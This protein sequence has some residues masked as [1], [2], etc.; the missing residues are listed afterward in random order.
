MIRVS[1]FVDSYTV[2]GMPKISEPVAAPY[3]MA[4][5]SSSL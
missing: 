5:L 4:C 1:S 2:H 3:E